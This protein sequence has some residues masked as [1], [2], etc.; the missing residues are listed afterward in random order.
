M[1]TKAYIIGFIIGIVAFLLLDA[2]WLGVLAR[3]LYRDKLGFLMAKQP[4]WPAA[5][6][7]YVFF[8]I[9]LLVL[10]IGPYVGGYSPA[11]IL[12]KGGVFGF[13]CYMTYD[14]TNWAVVKNWPVTLVFIDIAWGTFL[15]IATTGAILAVLKAANLIQMAS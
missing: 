4:F 14:L 15:A 2:I 1:S 7:F 10:A 8:I 11:M 6:A 3:E 13:M 9:G 5:V 12:V